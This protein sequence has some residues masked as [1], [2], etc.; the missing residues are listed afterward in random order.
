MKIP[1]ISP[2]RAALTAAVAAIS[3]LA[4]QQPAL[5]KDHG[6]THQRG[7]PQS[8]VDVQR[9]YANQP[10]TGFT[11]SFGTGYA[12]RGYYYGPPNSAYYYQ[13]SDVRYYATREAAPREYY[14]QSGYAG[15]S[16]RVAVQRALARQG[17]YDGS[18]DG[19]IGP[20]SRR[21]IFRYQ[22]ING[23]QPTGTITSS[24]LRSLGL[25]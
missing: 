2:S 9:V 5:A 8:R 25:N 13:R 6:S 11:L 15:Y 14:R 23:L 16:T 22:E 18:M 20:R 24:L 7:K 4:V 12:G 3:L 21:A 17:F 1:S 19:D 10:R